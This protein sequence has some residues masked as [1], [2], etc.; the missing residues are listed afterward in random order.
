M[1]VITYKWKEYISILKQLQTFYGNQCKHKHF[2]F[3]FFIIQSYYN[4]GRVEIWIMLLHVKK[5][6]SMPLSY[7]IFD[8]DKQN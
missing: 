6:Q 1:A 4:N 2:L 8:K 5:D 7:K 3:L